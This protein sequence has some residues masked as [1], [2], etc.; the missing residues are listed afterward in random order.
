MD[1]DKISVSLDE[2]NSSRVDAEIRRQDIAGRMAA[3]QAQ[4][5]AN[6]STSRRMGGGGFRKAIVY[7]SVFGLIASIVGWGMG[8]IV[9]YK[10]DHHPW[11][12]CQLVWDVCH[13]A[14]P[15]ATIRDWLTFIDNLRNSDKA[16]WRN[17]PYFQRSFWNQPEYA[18]ENAIKNA[19]RECE[20]LDNW[21]YVW[22]GLFVGLGLAIAEPIVGHN[23]QSALL[24][25]LLGGGLGALGG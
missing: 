23:G 8:E 24:R 5:E 14:K 11:A 3:H 4:V 1:N 10:Q 17:N 19:R 9:Q 2:V 6:T 20:R 12:Q 18:L 22:I 13:E 7:M 25:G 21:W 16:E 15:N